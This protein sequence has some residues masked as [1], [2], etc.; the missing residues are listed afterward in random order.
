VHLVATD[1]FS[2]PF[3]VPLPTVLARIVHR[4]YTQ[5]DRQ[6]L[7]QALSDNQKFLKDLK[8]S[9]PT[10]DQL[11]CVV[12]RPRPMRSAYI[13]ARPLVP[14]WFPCR[15]HTPGANLCSLFTP[16]QNPMDKM[17]K[18]AMLAKLQVLLWLEA[19]H[20]LNRSI[21]MVVRLPYSRAGFLL[22]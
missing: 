12:S 17:R 8:A 22:L 1:Y 6:S 21:H 5:H 4:K 7:P 9:Q 20:I 14:S 11:V 18:T 2:P 3:I 19:I 13:L 15:F 16:M 10:W